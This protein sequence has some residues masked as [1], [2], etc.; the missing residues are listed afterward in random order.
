MTRHSSPEPSVSENP[1][2]RC[3]NACIFVVTLDPETSLGSTQI[4]QSHGI[5]SQLRVEVTGMY[6]NPDWLMPRYVF[7]LFVSS[8]SP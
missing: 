5:P 4:A 7:I 1:R 3:V 2:I 6:L 8:P